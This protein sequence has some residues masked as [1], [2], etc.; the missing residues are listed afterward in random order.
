MDRIKREF[1]NIFLIFVWDA[2]TRRRLRQKWM[3]FHLSAYF[4][5]L[6]YCIR[7]MR[8]NSVL[9]IE[10]NDCH[11]EVMGGIIPYFQKLGYNVDILIN[12]KTYAEKPFC[13][14]DMRGVRVLRTW[15]SWGP[16]QLMRAKRTARY[17]HV[18]M[19]TS[20][21]Y[22]LQNSTGGY[23]C[24][25]GVF[26]G[27]DLKPFIIEHDLNDVAVFGE[28]KYLQSNHLITLGKFDRG[29]F[30]NPHKFGRTTINPKNKITT[31][32]TVG[33][34]EPKRK[35]HKMLI[36]AIENLA[37][38]DAPFRIIVIGNGNTDS[39]PAHIRQYIEFTGRLNFPKMFDKLESADFF[40]PLLDPE[41]V[42]HNRY[43]TTGV[44]GSA[45][46]IYGFAKIPVIHKKFADFYRFDDTNA[47]VYDD[48]LATAMLRAIEITPDEYAS[49]TANMQNTAQHIA[50]ESFNNLKR[51]LNAE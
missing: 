11:G 50:D 3:D 46:L 44:T 27:T 12:T 26:D 10:F 17:K 40:L 22:W 48:D 14:Q 13:R 51:I 31:F 9:L 37:K 1:I 36:D 49:H 34:I 21:C 47:I 8:P 45:Q 35:N 16:S 43:I 30:I 7:P 24:G 19:M 25:L 38:R 5:Y 32:V 6:W 20:A 29:T 4:K 33:G 18:I 15:T 41:T 28:E 42:A 2:P 23:V 39:F